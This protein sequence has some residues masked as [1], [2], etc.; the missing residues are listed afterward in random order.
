MTSVRFKMENHELALF[1]R[2]LGSNELLE[3][4]RKNCHGFAA[5]PENMVLLKQNQVG[6][7]MKPVQF[8]RIRCD[9]ELRD[10][11]QHTTFTAIEKTFHVDLVYE[12]TLALQG[13]IDGTRLERFYP[14]A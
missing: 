14:L 9:I 4:S 11:D 5:R 3:L 6:G 12:N 8:D 2:D 13:T 7:I 10:I 1:E